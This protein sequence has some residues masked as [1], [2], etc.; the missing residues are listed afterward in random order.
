[1]Y[2]SRMERCIVCTHSLLH[3]CSLCIS[4]RVYC[5]KERHIICDTCKEIHHMQDISYDTCETPIPGILVCDHIPRI[6]ESEIPGL[7]SCSGSEKW[8][9]DHPG[10]GCHRPLLDLRNGRLEE[11]ANSGAHETHVQAQ[12]PGSKEWSVAAATRM[13][14]CP[15]C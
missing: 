7:G 8:A 14:P 1:M 3:V 4:M 13:I 15:F 6:L 2:V 11:R 10:G 9:Q 12:R 5:P